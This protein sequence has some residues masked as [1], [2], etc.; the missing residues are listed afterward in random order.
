MDWAL[1][2][3]IGIPGAYLAAVRGANLSPNFTV[4]EMV[5]SQKGGVQW[6]TP[7]ALFNLRQLA[8]KVLQ[9]ARDVL[10]KPMVITSGYRNEATNAA[11]GGVP[12]SDHLTGLGADFK[13]PGMSVDT[14]ISALRA[15]DI[16]YYQLIAY[17]GHVHI[18]YAPDVVPPRRQY[19]DS[20]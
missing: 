8:V 13:V 1:V 19:I 18:S 3:A 10:R 12:N 2:A 15:T 17:N 9:P 11:V 14:I 6:P 4:W 7:M 5:Q 20:R 16:P